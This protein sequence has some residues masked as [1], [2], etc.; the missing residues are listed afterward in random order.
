MLACGDREAGRR[1]LY[2]GTGAL[3][4]CWPL[5][6]LAAVTA[7]LWRVYRRRLFLSARFAVLKSRCRRRADRLDQPGRPTERAMPPPP[8]RRPRSI[9]LMRA[10]P[11]PT[12]WRAAA[13][14]SSVPW[15][16]PHTGAGG[17]ITPLAASYSEGGLHLP[18]FPGELRP[19][20]IGGLAARR[21]L[22]HA[23][24]Q[25]G[26]EKPKTP[27]AGLIGI[28]AARTPPIRI[29][30]RGGGV[31]PTLAI[32]MGGR[33]RPRNLSGVAGGCVI[34]MRCL[35]VDR[36]ASAADIKSA[37]RR[38][39]KKLHP[40]ANKND[41]K[42]ASRFAELN[43]AY[44]ILGDDDKRKAYRSRRDR[45]RGQAALP[46]LSTASAPAHARAA[47]FGRTG[48]FETFSFGPE[49]FTRSTRRRPAAA[50]VSAA[51]RTSSRRLSAATRRRGPRARRC[52]RGRGFRQSAPT[53]QRR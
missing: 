11:P 23:R 19:R 33:G 40:D 50:A 6:R 3:R 30:L 35:G 9:S 34:P 27:Q 13:K 17:N 28:I 43:A 22:P 38:L 18:R 47:G 44:E 39:A 49:G 8:R 16:N 12:C 36:K 29:A 42:A 21:G 24:G 15:E 37:F 52:V 26:G 48:D 7:L 31:N 41:P 53:S 1:S 32:D 5:Q 4:L 10:R 46:G 2:S 45:R 25:V 20:R 14:D 51:S